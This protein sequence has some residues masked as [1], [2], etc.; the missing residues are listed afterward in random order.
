[1]R[2]LT[3]KMTLGLRDLQDSDSHDLRRGTTQCHLSSYQ[4]L[5]VLL[6]HSNVTVGAERKLNPSA[7]NP[8]TFLDSVEHVNHSDLAISHLEDRGRQGK[9]FQKDP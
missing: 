2:N 1:M 7:C 8:E 9:A 6:L 3:S 5:S 4:L